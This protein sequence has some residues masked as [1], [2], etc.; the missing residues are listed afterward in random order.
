[1]GLTGEA[2]AAP[3][4]GRVGGVAP[5]LGGEVGAPETQNSPGMP[6]RAPTPGRAPQRLLA[7]GRAAAAA[8]LSLCPS[9]G[10]S[11]AV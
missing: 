4:Y 10:P 6:P 9:P 1:M 2:M 11:A 8:G 7:D 3:P 5:T